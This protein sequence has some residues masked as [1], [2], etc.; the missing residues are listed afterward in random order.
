MNMAETIKMYRSKTKLS[1]LELGKALG[2][3]AQAVSKWECGTSEP[4]SETILKMCEMFG[5]TPDE[6]LGFESG[7][8]PPSPAAIDDAISDMLKGLSPAQIQRV[9]DFVAGLRASTP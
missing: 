5:I 9:R 8:Q 7:K 6:M 1:Q 2:V 4:N 3:T